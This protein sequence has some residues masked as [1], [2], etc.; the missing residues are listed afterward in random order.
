VVGGNHQISDIPEAAPVTIAT[1]GNSVVGAM[2]E[3]NLPAE[4]DKGR[5]R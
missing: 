3:V 1:P 2:L 5:I 4:L